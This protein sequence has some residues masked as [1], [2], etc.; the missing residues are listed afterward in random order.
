MRI[1]DAAAVDGNIHPLEEYPEHRNPLQLR[2][3]HKVKIVGESY[4]GG[5][6]I[7]IGTMVGGDDIRL[8][9]I[10][11]SLFA[12]GVPDAGS[13]QD[14]VCPDFL[15]A[16]GIGEPFL[17]AEQQEEN[18]IQRQK[19]EEAAQEEPIAPDSSEK[20]RQ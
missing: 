4:V 1:L 3:A 13:E 6:D 9:R 5:E 2:F 17:F 14:P 12:D 8:L 18:G 15:Q 10:N 11:L 19:E 7:E 20:E 16:P